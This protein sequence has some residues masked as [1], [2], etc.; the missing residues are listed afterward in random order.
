MNGHAHSSSKEPR[1]WIAYRIRGAKATWLG[2]VE[3]AGREAAI[4]TVAA[5]VPAVCIVVQQVVS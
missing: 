4:A 3:A 1:T 2:H 5:A